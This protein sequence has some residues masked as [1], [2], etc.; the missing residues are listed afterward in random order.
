MGWLTK[1]GTVAKV[2]CVAATEVSRSRGWEVKD[3]RDQLRAL[4]SSVSSAR[5][6]QGGSISVAAMVSEALRASSAKSSRKQQ[7]SI[8][9]ACARLASLGALDRCT[10]GRGFGFVRDGKQ[11]YFFHIS[12]H[13][14]RRGFELADSD[15]GRAMLYLLGMS[16]RNG[17]VE[18]ID[19]CFVDELPWPHGQA[20][21]T[22]DALNAIRSSWFKS[23][24][25]AELFGIVV[26]DWHLSRWGS[27][28]KVARTL[29]HLSD[30]LLFAELSGFLNAASEE[31]LAALDLRTL[32][33]VSPYGFAAE[34][35]NGGLLPPKEALR[36]FSLKVLRH[37]Y[38]IK[39]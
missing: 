11:N 18:I 25:A 30:N 23:Q 16:P 7:G 31:T 14:F 15:V 32:L 39:D 13:L 24:G 27:H 36:G 35:K 1:P 3:F 9:L 21:Q 17:Q 22:Q 8:D 12:G 10:P 5:V 34:W 37:L 28:T 6:D 2:A 33:E 38:C 26:A 20:P 19:W 4:R 29:A